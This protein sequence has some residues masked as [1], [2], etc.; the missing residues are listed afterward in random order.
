MTGRQEGPPQ[1]VRGAVEVLQVH[2]YRL[3]SNDPYSPAAGYARY[4]VMCA[5]EWPCAPRTEAASLIRLAD[6]LLATYETE[7][8]SPE[9]AAGA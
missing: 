1:T 6:Q 5:A 8:A 9:G 4:C 7:H 3:V 2:K